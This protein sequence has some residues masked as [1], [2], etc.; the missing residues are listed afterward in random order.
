[1]YSTSESGV[2][3]R[4]GIAETV[5]IDSDGLWTFIPEQNY[6]SSI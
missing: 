4:A 2:V 3:G 5:V 6:F 1:M